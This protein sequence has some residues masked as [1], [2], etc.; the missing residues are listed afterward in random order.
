MSIKILHTTDLHFNK[1]WFHWIASEQE[2]YDVF[3]ITGD[4]L[5]PSLDED[6]LS[7]IAWVS[8]WIREFKKP[9]FVCSGNHDIEEMDNEEWLNQISNIYGDN[10]KQ[11][12]KGV[13]FGS[14]PY[15]GAD[16]LDFCDCD[17]VLYHL[18]PTNTKTAIHNK[19]KDDWGDKELYRLLKNKLLKP[20]Y[21]L[22]GHMHHPLK[23]VDTI[24]NCTIINC[25]VDKK[26]HIPKHYAFEIYQT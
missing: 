5:E 12:I 9:L 19:T 11:T 25:G 16:F 6:L 4:F 14:V 10:A 20:K 17:V 7:Q 13:R 1:D 21:L 23:T 24:N 18:P 15:I 26:S 3:C 2:N 22:C 8:S